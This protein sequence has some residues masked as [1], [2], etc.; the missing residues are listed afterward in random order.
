[1]G[2]NLLEAGVK[3]QAWFCHRGHP[4]TINLTAFSWPGARSP[5]NH[6]PGTAQPMVH[7]DQTINVQGSVPAAHVKT[8]C[9]LPL[10]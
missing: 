10:P 1:M 7:G 2:S 9:L 3:K 4:E 8:P 5:G 6:G